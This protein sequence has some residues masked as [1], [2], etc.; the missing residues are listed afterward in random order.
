MP[1]SKP[2][3]TIDKEIGARMR[4]ARMR[5]GLSQERLGEAVDV[6]FQQ[7]Q[8]Y[9]RGVNRV[10]AS[11]IVKVA[12]FLNVSVSYL[13]LGTDDQYGNEPLPIDA[14]ALTAARIVAEMPA[15]ARARAVSVL[16]T[17]A[18]LCEP[19]GPSLA[20]VDPVEPTPA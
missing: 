17:V 8:K 2:L 7:I 20:T 9:E 5:K 18:T 11:T 13:L 6:T 14:A 3:T 19:V 1:R 4:L 12:K 15:P 10:S 16:R